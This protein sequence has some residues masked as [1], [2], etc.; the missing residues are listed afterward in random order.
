MRRVHEANDGV[1]HVRCEDA[2][3]DEFRFTEIAEIEAR[4]RRRLAIE[5]RIGGDEG[6]DDAVGFV[7]REAAHADAVGFVG[8]I[9]KQCW[10]QLADAILRPI[11]PAVI[12]ALDRLHAFVGDD[13]A[14][15]KRHRAVRANIAH[16]EDFALFIAP[17]QHRLAQ[18]FAAEHLPAL[19]LA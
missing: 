1:V 10:D 14:G 6:E 9:G 3:N 15:R 13:P 2:V 5:T 8:L 17:E 18:D 7:S 12:R 19:Q 4:R 11:T 16:G